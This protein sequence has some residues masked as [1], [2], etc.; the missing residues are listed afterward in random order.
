LGLVISQQGF[1]Q[2]K[3]DKYIFTS[4]SINYYPEL[5]S[6]SFFQTLEISQNQLVL[7]YLTSTSGTF[8]IA[9]VASAT[10]VGETIN[11]FPSQILNIGA[12]FQIRN[13]NSRFHEFSLSRFSR[14]KSSY[15]IHYTFLDTDGNTRLQNIG[16]NQKSF[17]ISLRYEYGKMFGNKKNRF[18]FGISGVIEPTFYSYQRE[19]LSIQDFPIRANIFSINLGVAPN[20]STRLSKKVFLDFKIIPNF[21]VADF[22][23]ARM[24]NPSLPIKGQEGVREYDLPEI[25]VAGTIQLRYLLQEPKKKRKKSIK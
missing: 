7:Q 16:Y 14:F 5:A 20:L 2:K 11:K 4:S 9:E 15:N 8:E 22:G 25:D 3:K 24:N 12:S 6:Y 19:V 17:I 13:S 1:S 21:L 23:K 10:L 18:R